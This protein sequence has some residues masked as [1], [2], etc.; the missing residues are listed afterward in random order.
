[1]LASALARGA[2]GLCLALALPTMLHAQDSTT[3]PDRTGTGGGPAST[4]TAP[5]TNAEGVT[6][7]PGSLG[8]GEV[9]SAAEQR[10]ERSADDRI[11]RSI[12]QGCN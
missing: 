2:A 7:P 1:M 12:C 6:K 3:A 9:P 10:R 8:P 5:Y 4:I 11:E